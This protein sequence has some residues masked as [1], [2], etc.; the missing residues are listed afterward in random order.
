MA[1]SMTS[2]QFI[3]MLRMKK[4]VKGA[5]IKSKVGGSY[6][7]T[8]IN[9]VIIYEAEKESEP[10]FCVP[11][12]DLIVGGRF[13]DLK[14]V[15]ERGKKPEFSE[16]MQ[17]ALKKADFSKTI[18]I[19]L[20]VDGKEI[21]DKLKSMNK[22]MKEQ[23][24]AHDP[25]NPRDPKKPADNPLAQMMAGLDKNA[26]SDAQLEKY[27]TRIQSIVWSF[28]MKKDLSVTLHITCKDN[29]TA[30]DS[31]KLMDAFLVIIRLGGEAAPDF[32][33][34][35]LEDLTNMKVSSSGTTATATGTIK[36]PPIVAFAKKLSEKK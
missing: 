9:D 15:I 19:A 16:V 33:K 11:E 29:V 30:E 17:T 13:K 32:P 5:D 31:R 12:S 23:N 26:P 3:V 10:S 36:G 18:T 2:E 1:G 34:E 7:E 24:V 22:E 6:K 21:V 27:S 14:A 20:A 25:K 4:A 8:K 35:T 28:D